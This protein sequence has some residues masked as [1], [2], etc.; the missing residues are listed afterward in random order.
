MV[1]RANLSC[2]S[3]CLKLIGNNEICTVTGGNTP[4]CAC[5]PGYVA[6][7]GY[8]CV[9]E[10]P[11][12]LRLKHDPDGD[13]T[14]RLKQGDVYKEHAVDIIDDNA[15]AYMRSLKITYSQPL[16]P[17]C[18]TKMGEFHVN[19]TVA[20]P[21]TSTKIV[22][23]TRRVIIEDIDECSLDVTK[24]ETSCPEL[25][26]QCDFDAGATC[27][28]K[29]GTYSCSCP[30]F[31]TGDGF[32]AISSEAKQ[33]PGYKGGTG[34]RDTS[35]PVIELFGPNPKAFKACKLCGLT[36]I[37]GKPKGS[38]ENMCSDLLLEQRKRYEHDIKVRRFVLYSSG[39]CIFCRIE[40]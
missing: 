3:F 10:S 29:K 7:D 8:G 14:T 18:L 4:I 35:K 19:Y 17:G 39:L 20:T 40:I 31:T 1:I 28:N 2:L 23:V 13:S 25:V 21:W 15:E 30:K 5:K 37:M 24:Y 26:P 6:V 16:P 12:I 34:C 38:G 32:K 11:P 33:P 9:D 36:G 27:V 22:R